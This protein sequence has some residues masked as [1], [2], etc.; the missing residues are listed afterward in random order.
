MWSK[1]FE[2]ERWFVLALLGKGS[3]ASIYLVKH[4]S[5]K[6]KEESFYAMKEIHKSRIIDI[7]LA[8]STQVERQTLLELSHP[9]I[10][11]L[12]Y[13]FQTPNTLYMIS[14]FA[15]G[16]DLFFHLRAKGSFSE[17][18]A[19]FYGA[20][21]ILGL[22]HLHKNNI[23]YRDLKPEN[24]LICK[25]GYVK[26]ADFGIARNVVS[27]D[28]LEERMVGTAQYMA[29]EQVFHNIGLSFSI[30]AWS[31]GCLMY[32]LVEGEPFLKGNS[33]EKIK[34]ELSSLAGEELKLKPYFSKDFKDLLTQLICFDWKKR[35]CIS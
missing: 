5:Q 25:T 21:I 10:L 35:P 2:Y 32:E 17:K 15:N 11:K 30:D 23:I 20:Q 12:K 22:E 29:P 13:A 16:G 18:Q 14:E 1:G 28:N 31:F 24:I 34:Q 9:F 27:D 7:T 8:T 4:V 3:Y 19:K 26:L 33:F 6:T